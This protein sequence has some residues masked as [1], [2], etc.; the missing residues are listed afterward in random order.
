MA[1]SLTIT[2]I[3]R[4]SSDR[5]LQLMDVIIFDVDV[6]AVL[7]QQAVHTELQFADVIL[8]LVVINSW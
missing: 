3:S 5:D 1:K 2:L 4:S 6:E 8:H 7:L